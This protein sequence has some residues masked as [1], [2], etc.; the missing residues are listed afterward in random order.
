MPSNLASTYEQN[1]NG[2]VAEGAGEENMSD[3]VCPV[4]VGYLLLNPLRK[5]FENPRRVLGP[6]VRPGMTV[7]EPG[8]AMGYFTL[9]LA[10]MVGPEGR[11]VAV[12]L[13]SEMLE[14]LARRAE[15]AGLGGVVETRLARPAGLGVED[16]AGRVDFAAAI[17]LMH[18]LPDQ[19]GFLAQVWEAL[20]PGGRLLIIEPKMHVK[21][22]AFQATMDLV[23]P[24]GFR[25]DERSTEI[26][27][28]R[29]L[30]VK[31]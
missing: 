21:K 17:H 2:P 3:H 12:D 26:G 5:I 14:G 6:F 28:R 9:P 30:L 7:L 27:A 8:C 20:K 22:G 29:A 15:K 13:Q 10:R 4:W 23:E 25:V 31:P 19:A 18:E 1:M 24:A 16:L 11:V